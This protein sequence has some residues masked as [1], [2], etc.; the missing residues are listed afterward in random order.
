MACLNRIYRTS[1]VCRLLSKVAD[2]YHHSLLS[3]LFSAGKVDKAFSGSVVLKK[4]HRKETQ[5][6]SAGVILPK[7][8]NEAQEWMHISIRDLSVLL[9]AWMLGYGVSY[10]LS[11]NYI[12]AIILLVLALVTL[13]GRNFDV[14]VCTVFCNSLIGRIFKLKAAQKVGKVNQYLLYIVALLGAFGI[15]FA[16]PYGILLGLLPIALLL[17]SITKPLFLICLIML[18]LPLFGTTVCMVLSVLCFFSHWICRLSGRIEKS[19]LDYTDILFLLFVF[20]CVIATLFSFAFVDSLKV[21]SMWITLCCITF[22]IY[23]NIKSIKDLNTVISCLLISGFFS[24][25]FGILQYLSGQVD[26][27][28]TDTELFEDLTIRV[29]STF[30]N[31]NVF[32]EFLL[33]LAPLA[34]GM[35]LYYNKLGQKILC[36]GVSIASLIAL[37]L[38]YSR[39]CYVGI[40][41]TALVFLWMYNK[42]ILG[43]ALL[44]GIPIGLRFL[45]SN[46]IARIASVANF[47]DTS[48]SYRMKIYQGTGRMLGDMW[49]SGVGIGEQAFNS[50]YPF[51]STQGVVAQHSHSLLFQL[52]VTFGIVGMIYFI[53][54]NVV[55]HRNVISTARQFPKN[56]KNRLLLIT[57]G[58]VLFG[59]IVQGIFD[60]TW[61]NY[62]IYLLFWIVLALGFSAVKILNREAEKVHD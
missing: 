21:S 13:I 34:V 25:C 1:I 19:K 35:S 44:V 29:Y 4:L 56:D 15:I 28:W 27:T 8:Q 46:I 16:P 39:G 42:A 18:S 54:L 32:G 60:Y 23:R 31:P 59:F 3:T 33:I 43:C 17:M 12:K 10:A 40:A 11:Q 5:G 41:V 62:R 20:L 26:T 22:I 55:Y 49:S 14:S 45:P 48:T 30:A 24:A 61:Y 52:L 57:F 9:S 37:A 50:V 7:L 53:L 2:A 36:F 6:L 58:S 47:A 51:Y 38:T